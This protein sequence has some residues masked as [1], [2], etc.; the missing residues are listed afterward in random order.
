MKHVIVNRFE[1]LAGGLYLTDA[2]KPDIQFTDVPQPFMILNGGHLKE[3]VDFV[4][5]K[6]DRL[7]KSLPYEVPYMTCFWFFSNDR[8]DG[9]AVTVYLKCENDEIIQYFHRIF[10]KNKER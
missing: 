1:A 7:E 2:R 3:R 9:T 6:R 8:S 10:D 5:E 4:K